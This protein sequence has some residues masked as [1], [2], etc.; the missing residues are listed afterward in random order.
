MW[1]VIIGLFSGVLSSMG[2]GGGAILIPLLSILGVEQK[3]AQVINVAVFIIM[4]IFILLSRSQKQF[5]D[6]FVAGVLGL[7]GGVISFIASIFVKDM[8]NNLLKIMF[9]IFLVALAIVEFI[10]FVRKYYIKK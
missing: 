9:G 1:F 8:D 4:V 10:I 6:Y 5:A 2:L 3:S 7:I